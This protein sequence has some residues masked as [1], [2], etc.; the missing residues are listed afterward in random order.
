MRTIE[1]VFRYK[2]H[3]S[4]ETLEAWQRALLIYAW[5]ALSTAYAPYSRFRVGAAV[6]LDH[7]QIVTGSNQENAS[8]PAGLC[9]ERTALAVAVMT[10]PNRIIKAIAIR[11]SAENE[12]LAQ[13]VAPCGICRQ[14]LLEQEQRQNHAI[15]L[16]LQGA[17]GPIAEISS[18]KDMLPLYFW[19]NTGGRKY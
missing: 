19:R 17:A 9:A 8:S 13:P 18:V 4:Y 12:L 6:Q 5:E 16:L 2:Q 15:Q 3:D 7:G 1:E 10:Y 11:A 14:A